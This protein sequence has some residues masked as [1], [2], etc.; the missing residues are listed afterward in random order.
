MKSQQFFEELKLESE[1][2]HCGD[3]YKGFIKALLIR[4]EEAGLWK[5]VANES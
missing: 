2:P 5:R 4:A 3:F 1:K